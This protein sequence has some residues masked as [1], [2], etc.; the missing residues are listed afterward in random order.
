MLT[1]AL[2]SAVR[3][4]RSHANPAIREIKIIALTANAVSG[5][6]ERFLAMGMDIYLSKPVRAV[7]LEE[8]IMECLQG[9]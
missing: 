3:I 5:D 1:A 8:A 4:I 6:K 7:K 2:R 9:L